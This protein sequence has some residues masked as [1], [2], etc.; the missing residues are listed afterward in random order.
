MKF[1]E[2]KVYKFH[3]GQ[4]SLILKKATQKAGS[5]R[6]L[7]K[8]I[9]IP[10]R[11]L[12]YYKGEEFIIPTKRLKKIIMYL[13]ITEEEI[14][15]LI[16]DE[17]DCNWGARLGALKTN[18][19]KSREEINK[20]ME[21]IR[22]FKKPIVY[23]KI[24]QITNFFCELYG[25][26]MGDG[27]ISKYTDYQGI[28]RLDLIITGDKMYEQKFYQYIKQKLEE[29]FNIYS[30]LYISKKRNELR[31]TIRNKS[32]TN[33]MIRI[34]FPHGKK[35]DKL[36]IP[37][38]L[39]NLE[40]GRLKL[41]IR[42]LFDTDGSIFAKKNENYR[43]PYICI[44]TKSDRFRQQIINILREK[45]YPAYRNNLN[46]FLK[47]IRNIKNW[48]KDIGTSNPKHKFKYDYWLTNGKLPARLLKGR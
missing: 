25:I 32:F 45:K 42:G 29:E 13:K 21:Y 28:K 5:L 43:Y 4:Q 1:N 47:G 30:Y 19:N 31:L 27:C 22:S 48:M 3:Q 36:L 15:S 23:N 24:Y 41:I 26:A 35:Y 33:F 14:F 44:T 12:K 40:W 46:I 17:L 37:K 9:E 18:S 20:H 2:N 10:E 39:S 38:T 16:G 7:S 34:G 6:K 11:S 8:I